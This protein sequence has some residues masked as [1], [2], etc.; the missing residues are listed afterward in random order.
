[1]SKRSFVLFFVILLIFIGS[2]THKFSNQSV[3]ITHIPAETNITIVAPVQESVAS[4]QSLDVK[5]EIVSDFE[6]VEAIAT[7]QEV[8]ES[9][10]YDT[11]AGLFV[12]QVPLDEV[13]R[14]EHNLI[15]SITDIF[16]NNEQEHVLF[17][18]DL[19]PMLSIESP[20]INTMTNSEASLKI[21]CKDDDPAGCK[22]IRVR[23]NS[24]NGDDI[25]AEGVNEIDGVFSL[26]EYDGEAITL[27][28]TAH[29]FLHQGTTQELLIYVE[30]S[31]RLKKVIDVQGKILAADGEKIFYI[32]KS[33]GYSI[34]KIH[35]LV[36]GEEASLQSDSVGSPLYGYFTQYGAI[37]ISS[38]K[39]NGSSSA[40]YMI[41][42][43][44]NDS[45]IY[46]GESIEFCSLRK[47][48]NYA[49]WAVQKRT[50]S[51]LYI[52]DISGMITSRFAPYAGACS[53]DIAD[54]LVVFSVGRNIFIYQIDGDLLTQIT[55]HPT[56]SA[57]DIGPLT[58]GTQYLFAREFS[59]DNYGLVL[60]SGDGDN[61]EL[62]IESINEL[63][64]WRSQ[65]DIEGG[66]IIYSKLGISSHDQ[67]WRRSPE[68]ET[69]Q[70]TFS[71]TDSS[72][73]DSMGSGG[74]VIY[75]NNER[76]FWN[77]P[78]APSREIGSSNF[79]RTVWT[80]SGPYRIIGN[81]LARIDPLVPDLELTG[82][83]AS[84][85]LDQGILVSYTLN[86]M[87]TS[88]FTATDVTLVS[89]LSESS[90]L[91]ST[92]P[93]Q[94][95][96]DL[97]EVRLECSWDSFAPLES[98]QLQIVILGNGPEDVTTDFQVSSAIGDF[99][100]NNSAISL[101]TSIGSQIFLPFLSFTKP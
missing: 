13:E 95:E 39:K 11:N 27:F 99:D 66:W 16:G 49:T 10:V 25:L 7:V 64:L 71:G 93:K 91:V 79:G 86:I 8:S 62:L 42:E 17:T 3:A 20:Q 43:W 56:E 82:E 35:N 4:G 14:G 90:Q 15:I 83:A 34:L 84:Q 32:D 45:L 65:Y 63:P 52:R 24:P 80:D 54:G 41:L 73:I 22:F 75:E 87:N 23:V 21:T 77:A 9:L 51:E 70:I 59:F 81:T 92:A 94:L 26:D 68:G 57:V 29:D 38:Y 89:T 19:K 5:V 28:V 40:N 98:T 55:D 101:T 33:K 53:H 67:L 74:M 58:D 96:C 97:E 18:R 48:G 44:H 36:T 47:D 88:P 31:E 46:H 69:V 78:G 12:A 37:F 6:L 72:R 2:I 50:G 85:R 60:S 30:S 100:R 1:M 61:E 76:L